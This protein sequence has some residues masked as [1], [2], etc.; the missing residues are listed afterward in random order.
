MEVVAALLPSAGVAFLFWLAV[1]T[2]V[3]AD[4]RER[5]AMAALEREDARRNSPTV[6]DSEQDVDTPRS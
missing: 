5:S 6:S 3:N 4:R 2:M 1:R